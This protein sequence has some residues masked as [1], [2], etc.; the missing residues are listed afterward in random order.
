MFGINY[1]KV[2]NLIEKSLLICFCLSYCKYISVLV[3]SLFIFVKLNYYK[4]SFIL[5]LRLN[6]NFILIGNIQMFLF[7]IKVYAH[8]V[9]VQT[10]HMDVFRQKY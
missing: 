1:F 10:R 8:A 9:F 7:Q 5:M 4:I 2:A 3:A 6:P